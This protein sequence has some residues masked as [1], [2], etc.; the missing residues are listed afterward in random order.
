MKIKK[1]LITGIA[2]SGGS[3]LAEYIAN[4]HPEVEINGIA[5][6]RSTRLNLKTLDKRIVRHEADLIDFGSVLS[7]L[8]KTQPDAIFHL[9]AYANVRASFLTPNTFLSNNILGTSNLF[10]AIRAAHLDPVIQLCSTSEVYGQV[11][12]KDVP[13]KESSPLKPASPYAV[14]KAT[15]DL[16][17][18]SY[19]NSYQMRIIRTRMFSYLNPRRSDLF[20]SSFY[21]QV[22]WIERDLQKEL[23][24]GNLESVRTIIDI[25]DAM[26]AYWLA[27]IH[28]RP[29]EIY[30][31]GGTTSVKV[32][33]FLDKLI[34]LSS[35]PI[36]TRCDPELLRPADVTLQIPCVG[37]FSK[38]T[39]WEP[40]Y[41]FDE[42]VMY[43]LEYWRKK[44]DD[45]VRLRAFV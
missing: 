40:Q 36:K 15:Q 11:D 32:G 7:V 20:A 26:R 13:I 37:K 19:F 9:A 43:L 16:L 30:N 22:A 21:K 29:G 2:G 33:D 28:C 23:T 24:H 35:V 45:E 18:W 44:A 25:R 10:E 14:S 3:Y 34:L 8:N 38:E 27:I 1:V 5:Y 6:A 12:P 39:G 41:N 42:S 31:I 17:G 4:N